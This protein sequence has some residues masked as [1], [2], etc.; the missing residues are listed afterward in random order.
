MLTI[1]LSHKALEDL[2]MTGKMTP[3]AFNDVIEQDIKWL[4]EIINISD[5]GNSL[6]YDHIVNTLRYAASQYKLQQ[7]PNRITWGVK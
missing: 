4:D 3:S 2:K 6:E 1:I 5:K 7:K